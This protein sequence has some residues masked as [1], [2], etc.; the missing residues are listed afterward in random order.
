[1]TAKLQSQTPVL[2]ESDRSMLR[3]FVK[4]GAGSWSEQLER[5]G[6]RSQ[7]QPETGKDA[8]CRLKANGLVETTPNF[9]DLRKPLW[10]LT[11][12]G[13]QLAEEVVWR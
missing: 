11:P 10:K 12:D 7:W 4:D 6:E 5:F 13:E 1:M 3:V 8:L 2:N 9:D